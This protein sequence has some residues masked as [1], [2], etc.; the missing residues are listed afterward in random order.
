MH[1]SLSPVVR[2]AQ[3]GV[4]TEPSSKP[5]QPLQ[6]QHVQASAVPAAIASPPASSCLSWAPLFVWVCRTV[7]VPSPICARAPQIAC[8]PQDDAES[9]AHL[10]VFNNGPLGAETYRSCLPEM[11]YKRQGNRLVVQGGAFGFQ[12]SGGV[13]ELAPGVPIRDL[14]LPWQKQVGHSP[15]VVTC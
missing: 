8:A 6:D 2:V 12:M 11:A 1:R 9:T 14:V 10:I 15:Q 7:C 4:A 3:R 5:M 13:D